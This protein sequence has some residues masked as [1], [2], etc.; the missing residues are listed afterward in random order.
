MA[1]D[2][3]KK[4][5]KIGWLTSIGVQVVL[6][7]LFYFLVA[8]KEPF[9]PIPSYGI[10]L[11][12][13]FESTGSGQTPVN[14]PTPA[15]ATEPEVEEASETEVE[16]PTDEVVEES[17]EASDP[18][19]S[20]V[21]ADTQIPVTDQPSPDV[22]NEQASPKEEV[23]PVKEKTEQT[24]EKPKDEPKKEPT[25]NPAASMPQTSDATNKSKGDTGGEGVAGKKEGTVD[26]RAL[27]GDQGG[28]NG[29]SLQMAGWVWDFK[30]DPKDDSSESG[31]IVYRIKIDGDGYIID[32]ELVSSTVSPTVERYYRQS[33]ERL[34]F[35]KTND[36]KPAPTSSG[37]VTFIIR[38]K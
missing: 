36:Y 6:L 5:R 30:P 2:Q 20:E 15:D 26:G 1:E 8:W 21:G 29:A 3:E 33:I 7:L 37:T 38:S 13:G 22:V 31:K 27:M 9:P 17:I 19:P 18:L 25:L 32:I 14:N 23:K 11:S 10:E 24:K 28:A 34:S 12:F 35:S 16:N 4:Y